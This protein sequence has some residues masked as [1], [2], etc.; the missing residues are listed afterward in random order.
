MDMMFGQSDHLRQGPSSECIICF[1]DRCFL[2]FALFFA[3]DDPYGDSE[4]ND[5]K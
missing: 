3:E 2:E 5:F 4:V 1:N